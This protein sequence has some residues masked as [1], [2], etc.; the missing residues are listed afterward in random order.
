M[1]VSRSHHRCC[2]CPGISFHRARSFDPRSLTD[3]PWKATDYF[4]STLRDT[5][6]HREISAS[7]NLIRRE[8]RLRSFRTAAAFAL[9][10]LPVSF[11]SSL[12]SPFLFLRLFAMSTRSSARPLSTFIHVPF[13]AQ[14]RFSSQTFRILFSAF[15]LK[16]WK[17]ITEWGNRI[18]VERV[19]SIH[20]EQSIR[21]EHLSNI[22]CIV[23]VAKSIFWSFFRKGCRKGR[24]LI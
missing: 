12:S 24:P 19:I 17:A 21:I 3:F 18:V 1:R 20:K 10:P 2:Y 16:S 9:N 11:C 6:T 7:D 15:T 22:S 8:S 13:S 4:E 14:L 5:S 23:R